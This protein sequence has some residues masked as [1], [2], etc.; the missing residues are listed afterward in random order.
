MDTRPTFSV[1]PRPDRVPPGLTDEDADPLEGLRRRLSRMDTLM[2][3]LEADL[4]RQRE[5]LAALAIP[6][7]GLPPW[8]PDGPEQD[9]DPTEPES[10]RPAPGPGRA[11]EVRAPAD[12]G[13]PPGWNRPA[14]GFRP[15]PSGP[16]SRGGWRGAGRRSGSR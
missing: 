2:T 10:A 13:R 15:V 3:L 11:A 12:A 6:P 4:D 16:A 14:G 1:P 8:E 5:A 7:G 9:A